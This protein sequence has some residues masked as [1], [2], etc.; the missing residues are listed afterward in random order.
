MAAMRDACSLQLFSSMPLK[1]T[2]AKSPAGF[3]YLEKVRPH[4][5][6]SQPK[7]GWAPFEGAT[8]VIITD[9]G[10]N[11]SAIRDEREGLC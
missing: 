4:H 9:N 11:S 8:A 5:C 6:S 1:S 3:S 10:A 7:A 2:C